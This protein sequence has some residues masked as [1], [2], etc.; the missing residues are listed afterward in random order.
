MVQKNLAFI[1]GSN[2]GTEVKAL[3][4]D[5]LEARLFLFQRL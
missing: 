3:L 1:F 5:H 2:V 4:L